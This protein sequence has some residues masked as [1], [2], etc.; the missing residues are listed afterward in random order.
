[1]E[2]KLRRL[3]TFPCGDDL[4]SGSLDEAAG[5][6]GVLM[7]M[8]GTQTRIGS[9]RMYE[10]LAN[11]LAEHGFSCLRYDR[12]G[13]G[14]SSGEDPGFKDSEA[15]LKAAADTFRA[16]MPA[17]EHV[18]GFGLCDGATTL[19]LHGAGSGLDGLVLVNPWLVEAEAGDMAP[20]AVR[21]HYRERLL[22]GAAWKKLITGGVNMGKLL[23][24][25]RKASSST[26]SSLA[27]QAAVGLVGAR[28]PVALILATGDGTAI[29]AA[30][31]VQK[32]AFDSL[33][34]WS[35]EIDT[36]SHT[37]A[38]SGDQ[39]ALEKAVLEALAALSA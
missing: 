5:T 14:D 26:D 27:E 31:E 20:A 28:C 15:D 22:S 8:G 39:E 10:R 33:I 16:E 36:D 17:V 3:L 32:G 30:G 4:L 25:L 13:V 24:G 35:R 18:I 2:A 37:F 1:M 34:S 12:R 21:A 38:R 6:T 29:A 19:A 11:G 9:H 7:V 23:G